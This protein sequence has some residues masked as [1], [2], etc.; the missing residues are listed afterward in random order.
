M[1]YGEQSLDPMCAE[2][3]VVAHGW[4]IICGKKKVRLTFTNE[5]RDQDITFYIQN[6]SIVPSEP[7]VIM[8]V[9][10]DPLQLVDSAEGWET[11]KS[12]K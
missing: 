2:V 7:S 1:P 4:A 3:E 8:Y 9:I 11:T 12:K 5:N 6:L 10:D